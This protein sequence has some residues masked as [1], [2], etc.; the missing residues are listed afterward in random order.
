MR[1]KTTFVGLLA[2]AAMLAMAAV[3]GRH[4]AAEACFMRAPQPVQVVLDRIEVEINENVATKHYDCHFANPNGN[5][6]VGG[7]CYMELD[8]D[9]QIDNLSMSIAGETVEA[10]ILEV[11]KA[12]Q[13]FQEIVATG[14]SPALLE[15]YGN[16]LVRT[17]VP[18]VPAG[19]EAVVQLQYT[20]VLKPV[21]GVYRLSMLN[22][23]PKM[24]ME[25]LKKA[26]VSIKIKSEHGVTNLYSPT[27]PI[28]IDEAVEDGIQVRWSQ[29]N[30]LPKNPFVIYWSLDD[31]KI[32]A[33]VL[34]HREAGDED[35]H[36]MIMVSPTM[37][38]GDAA[39]AVT[40]DDVMAKDIVFVTDTSG[41]MVENNKIEQAKDAL[42][43]CVENLRDGDR[44][45]I[46]DFSTTTRSFHA[47][48]LVAVDDESR[49]AAM[50][51]IDDLKARGGT[52]I[53]EA[54]TT[55]LNQFADDDR[56][57]MVFFTTDGLP[58]IG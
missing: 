44:F 24:K 5:A 28:Q 13:V 23:N 34:A 15:Y 53:G 9:A 20:Q 17:Q 37:M 27:H 30:Y 50:K 3:N 40:D 22:T 29:E 21:S 33:S 52:A 35:G 7:V 41:S 6:I 31:S 43:Y 57:K 26:E 39:G 4:Q 14:G 12:N 51:Y 2:V 46:V 47:D 45:N 56:L 19:G 11:G 54:L 49:A 55:A 25:V 48:G 32:G 38:K 58:T 16:R 36:F 1:R 8:P 42:R 18:N 10:E